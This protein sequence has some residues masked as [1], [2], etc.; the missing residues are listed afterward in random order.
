MAP[1]QDNDLLADEWTAFRE[2]S[3]H[4]RLDEAIRLAEQVITGS[5]D[6]VRRAQ[7]L[8][9]RL[10]CL[11]NTGNRDTVPP[12]L[13]QAEDELDTAAHPRLIGEYHLLAA[14]IAHHRTSYGIALLHVIMAQ[15]A[16][17]RMEERT[18]AA[19][20]AWHDLAGL[21]SELGYHLRGVQADRRAQ[22]LSS[23]LEQQRTIE[24]TLMANVPAA[25]FLDQRGDT[26]GC[27]R[28]LSEL[29]E[30]F[31][32][33]LRALSLVDQ[34]ILAYAV[35][36]LA[37]LQ[38][39]VTVEV[40]IIHSVGPLLGQLNKLGE[41][42]DALAAR[43][44]DHALALL[45]DAREP[46]DVIGNA[47]PLRLTSIGHSQLG[48][49]AEALATERAALRLSTQEEAE[50]R[51]LLV[52]SVGARIDQLELRRSAEQHARAA[53][54]D[55]LT[56]LPNRRKLDDFTTEL[57]ESGRT[58]TIGMLDLDKFKAINDYHGH[59]TGDIV[60]Q[61][62]AGILAREIRPQDLAARQG[63]DEFVIIL[64]DVTK[65]EAEALGERINAAIRDQDWS[66]IVPNTPVEIS[67]GW[68]ELDKDVGAAFRTADAELYETK[69]RHR[70]A[71][72]R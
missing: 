68:A 34:V 10:T 60:L 32:P 8:I 9:V 11:Y 55:P 63:G 43:R 52:D 30:E 26:D 25:I 33:H 72:D 62:I 20:D 6:P 15:R 7:A 39:P 70:A 47:E 49:H 45:A 69:R 31:H 38:H 2:L 40:P 64:L 35:R 24:T 22:D 14:K 67:V 51:T 66:M 50:L 1:R 58:A 23:D 19:V 59:P 48:N 61:R 54:T 44:P 16:L 29:V 41:V 17:E 28:W 46:L 36:R 27:V 18:R 13:K 4:G 65:N 57:A 37:V 53:L 3:T 5:A 42:C 12:R 56:G 71:A 21:Y